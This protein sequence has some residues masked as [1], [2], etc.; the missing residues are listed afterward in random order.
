MWDKTPQPLKLEKRIS[1]EKRTFDEL[2]IVVNH[3]C[4]DGLGDLATTLKLAQEL[5]LYFT[6]KQITLYF[7]RQADYLALRYLYPD[8]KKDSDDNEIGGVKL[9]LRNN[10]QIAE[11]LGKSLVAIIAP[12][13]ADKSPDH[14]SKFFKNAAINIY[15][16][17]PNAHSSV[18]LPHDRKTAQPYLDTNGNL[19]LALE[20]GFAKESIGF[21]LQPGLETL[22][23]IDRREL[24][25]AAKVDPSEIPYLLDAKWATAYYHDST[26][27]VMYSKVLAEAVRKKGRINMALFDFNRSDKSV[28]FEVQSMDSNQKRLA[29]LRRSGLQYV[30]LGPQSNKLLLQFLAQSDLPNLVT[31]DASLAESISLDKLFVYEEMPWKLWTLPYLINFADANLPKEQSSLVRDAF[32]YSNVPGKLR[33]PVIERDITPA[34]NLFLSPQ[35]QQAMHNLY[36]QVKEQLNL[37]KNLSQLI[38]DGIRHYKNQPIYVSSS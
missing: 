18:H 10:D 28:H 24:L 37:A 13:V 9:S 32:G 33:F 29:D 38:R 16:E 3:I 31:G 30:H 21:H 5:T 12:L 34:D 1:S 23:K 20:T 27:F 11:I 35:Y 25:E 36:K 22:P 7:P 19:H 8:F 15:L 4:N 26:G 14:P 2:P 17:E 6:E